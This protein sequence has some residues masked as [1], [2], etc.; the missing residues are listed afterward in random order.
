MARLE[1]LVARFLAEPAEVSFRD[2]ATLLRAFGYEERPTKSSH[3]VFVK[4]EILPI[5]VPTIGGRR[6]KR[7][8][9]WNIVE[10]LGLREWYEEHQDR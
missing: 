6:V 9:I 7:T 1:R 4:P 10:L 8:Y 3:H 5:T 2:V